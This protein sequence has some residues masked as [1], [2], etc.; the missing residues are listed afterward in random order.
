MG[1]I[2][3]NLRDAGEPRTAA[4]LSYDLNKMFWI[5]RDGTKL[6]DWWRRRAWQKVSL[7]EREYVKRIFE[8]SGLPV[9]RSHATDDQHWIE[10][11]YSWV[12]GKNTVVVSE[13]SRIRAGRISAVAALELRMPSVM[14]P[15]VQ[16]GFG[17]A[18]LNHLG[19]VIFHSDSK[20][21]LRE[22]FFA[23]TD[24]N[25]ELRAHLLART[26]HFSSGQY[27]GKDR[28]FFAMPLETPTGGLWSCIGTAQSWTMRNY[29]HSLP[30]CYFSSSI[31]L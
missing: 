11:T 10:P 25:E 14:D 3:W 20:R 1:T 9:S 6:V 29:G 22:D 21:N 23:E 24:Q 13:P 2:H 7:G 16:P 18:V 19:K 5:G 28:R 15:V 8:G 4:L 12:S 26:P 17:F 30:A 27:W 31:P